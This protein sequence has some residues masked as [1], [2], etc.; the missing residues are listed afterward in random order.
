MAASARCPT[1]TSC[2]SAATA[3]RSTGTRRRSWRRDGRADRDILEAGPDPG[4][5]E[6]AVLRRRAGGRA[7]AAA[8]PRLRHLHVADRRHRHAA[9]A[10]L[11]DLLLRR[12]RMGAGERPGHALQLRAHAPGV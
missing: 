11:P 12:A 1:T 2:S 7:A 5:A 6:P 9:A 8:L 3:A 4:R 10:A